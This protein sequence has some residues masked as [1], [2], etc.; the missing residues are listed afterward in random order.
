MPLFDYKCPECGAVREVLISA[1]STCPVMCNHDTVHFVMEKQPSAP[2]FRMTGFRELNGYASPR[3]IVTRKGSVT[4]TVSGNFEA[5][6]DG[7]A[8]TDVREARK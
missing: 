3:T 8:A 7:I 4:T 5:F 6:R 2:S 1:K